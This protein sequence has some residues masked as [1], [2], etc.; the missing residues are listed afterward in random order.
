MT[1]KTMRRL[2][3]DI[4]L[5]L[6]FVALARTSTEHEVVDPRVG[7]APTEWTDYWGRRRWAGL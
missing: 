4:R 6:E 1:K 2:M 7:P 3:A 5:Y